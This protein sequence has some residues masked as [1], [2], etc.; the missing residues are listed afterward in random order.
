M[1]L[2]SPEALCPRQILNRKRRHFLR[3]HTVLESSSPQ[4]VD[5]TELMRAGL[6]AIS[7]RQCAGRWCRSRCSVV[8]M[9]V[10]QNSVR[11]SILLRHACMQAFIASLAARPRP[12]LNV[13]WT[14][15][16]LR[17]HHRFEPSG[18]MDRWLELHSPNKATECNTC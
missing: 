12:G 4:K 15:Y 14:R 7:E 9:L 13:L 3:L 8:S 17:L 10:T 5:K 1:T 11:H 18:R 16:A 2:P 6:V